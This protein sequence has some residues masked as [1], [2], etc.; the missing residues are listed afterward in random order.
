MT[1]R[2]QR[3]KAD[4]AQRLQKLCDWLVVGLH[5]RGLE[6]NTLSNGTLAAYPHGGRDRIIVRFA[7]Q[8]GW[9]VLYTGKR[10]CEGQ[11]GDPKLQAT[12][13]LRAVDERLEMAA[14]QQLAE[15]LE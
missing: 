1:D 13:I 15:A 6:V 14:A 2:E 8:G 5:G 10:V 7:P 4:K 9:E 11:I 3:R 12:T